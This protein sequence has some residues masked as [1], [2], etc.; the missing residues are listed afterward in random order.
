MDRDEL[1]RALRVIADHASADEIDQALAE[2]I[3]ASRGIMEAADS[4]PAMRRV[5]R[6]LLFRICQILAAGDDELSGLDD[7]IARAALERRRDP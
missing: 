1:T 7:A 6:R 5:A 3:I 4:S 2:L